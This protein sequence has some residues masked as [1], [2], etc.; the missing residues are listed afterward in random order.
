M[1]FLITLYILFLSNF[2]IG[3]TYNSV[4]DGNWNNNNSW[5]P[6]GTPSANHDVIHIYH[7]II[8]TSDIVFS[9]DTLYIHGGGSL[10]GSYDLVVQPNCVLI[11]DGDLDLDNLTFKNGSVVIIN[12]TGNVT[13]NND[14]VNENNSDDVEINGVVNVIGNFDNGNGGVIIGVGSITA[15]SFSG[16]GTTFDVQPTNDI[17]DGS[18]INGGGLPVEYLFFTV[19]IVNDQILLEWKTASEINNDFY[20]I[21]RST[22]FDWFDVVIIPGSGNS[23]IER[24]YSYYDN[25]G[26]GVYYYRLKQVDY[27][28]Q[29]EYSP[30]LYVEF[31]DVYS[32]YKNPIS[33]GEPFIINNIKSGD[34][35]KII[36]MLGQ[37]SSPDSL[38]SGFYIVTVNG[39][40]LTKLIVK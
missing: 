16:K 32:I 9:F 31:L 35:I 20:I 18:T 30:I 28:G 14:L 25:V 33:V 19:K 3:S 22:I 26:F 11:I 29:F 8:M 6:T 21:Q 15:G 34:V 23:S 7:D 24:Y 4:Q 37:E 17:T 12:N 39:V 36:N 2:L 40:F 1:K 13:I 38:T 27:D 5:S 10:S